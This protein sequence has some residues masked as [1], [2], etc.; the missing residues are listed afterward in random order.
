MCHSLRYN[1]VQVTIKKRSCQPMYENIYWFFGILAY[2][3]E[4]CEAFRVKC[5]PNVQALVEVGGC[6]FPEAARGRTRYIFAAI[7]PAD[8]RK[9]RTISI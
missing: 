1:H 4:Q 2:I 8:R 7:S 5:M 9:I 3:S 6:G